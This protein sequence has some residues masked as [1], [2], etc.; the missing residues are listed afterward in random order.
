VCTTMNGSEVTNS[1][2]ASPGET[3]RE[4]LARLIEEAKTGGLLVRWADESV[5]VIGL[6]P[7]AAASGQDSATD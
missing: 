7:E 5:C 2:A 6:P 1:P 3:A 4:L